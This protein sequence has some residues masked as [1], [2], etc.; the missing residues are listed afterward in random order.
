MHFERPAASGLEESQG[1]VITCEIGPIEFTA[2]DGVSNAVI[3]RTGAKID[4]VRD[5]SIC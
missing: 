1:R 5:T 2:S 3:V 4:A